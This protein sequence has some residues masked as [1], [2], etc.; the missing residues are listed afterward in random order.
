MK[1]YKLGAQPR[2]MVFGKKGQRSLLRVDGLPRHAVGVEPT[3]ELEP[4]GVALFDEVFKWVEAALGGLSLYTAE[5][6]APG[7][8]F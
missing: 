8:Y 5:V 1:N 4:R 2:R 7:E 6:L 3:V